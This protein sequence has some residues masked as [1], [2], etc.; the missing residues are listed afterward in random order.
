MVVAVVGA[1]LWVPFV[2][3]VVTSVA[4]EVTAPIRVT[5]VEVTTHLDEGRYVV[6]EQVGT[7]LGPADVSVRP[8]GGDGVP[9]QYARSAET[10]TRNGVAFSGV[11]VF[12]TPRA[13]LYEVHVGGVPGREVIVTRSLG[14]TVRRLAGVFVLGL[15]GGLVFLA[16]VVMF[17]VGVMRR[18]SAKSGEPAP[19]YQAPAQSPPAGWYPDPSGV[20]Q[21]YW[22]GWRWTEHTA[23]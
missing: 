17:F 14:Q 8:P 5:P 10:I 20:G 13:G 23:P 15:V 16:G 11:L 22:D 2:V 1:L 18:S 3:R 21:R 19:A 7:T 12:D 6:F 4:G 9:I